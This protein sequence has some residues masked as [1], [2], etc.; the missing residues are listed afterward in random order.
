MPDRFPSPFEIQTPPGAEGWEQL[1]T[2]SSVF[3]EDRREYEEGG[4][5]F[6]DGVHWPEVL[7]PWDATFYEY[8][9]ASLSQ[10]NTR[11]YL[12]PPALGV[13]F[14]ILNGYAYL[15]PVGV[16]NPAEVEARVPHFLERA[17]FYF[18]NWDRLY[19]DWLVKIRALVKEMSEIEAEPLPEKEPIDVVTE[20]RG[21]G[22][23]LILQ[24]S[25]HKLLDLALRLWQYHFEFL[26]LGYAA[27][28]DFFGFLKQ[29]FPSIPDLAIAKMVAGVDVDLFRPDEELKKLARLAV[30]SGVDGAFDAGNPDEVRDTLRA[31]PAGQ[32]W[33]E[34]WEQA[35]EPWFNFS[36]GSGFY[37]SDR[38]WIENVDIPFGF[39]RDYIAKVKEGA[40]LARPI[41][42]L[43]AERDRIVAEYRELFSSD[44]DREAFDQKLGLARTVFPYVENHNFY[45]E[46]WSHSVLWRKMR[47]FGDVLTKAGF[48][49]EADD[50]FLLKRNEVPDALWDMYSAWAVG[51]EPRG[52]K[53][54]R[55]EIERRKGIRAALREW[56]AP[57][58]LGV[59]PEV[60]TEPFTVML[61]GITSDSVAG[62]LRASE[63]SDEGELSG[64]AA[65]P[66]VVEGPARVIF[67][68]DQ[69][70]EVEDGEI[71]VAPLTAPSWAPIFGKLLG[72]VT[73]VGGMMSH[74]AIVCREYGLPAVTGTAFGTSRIKTGQRIRLDG[75]KGTVTP[76]D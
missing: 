64:F 40:D 10:Y 17:G 31:T 53:Y 45:V 34:Q 52:G 21:T 55:P 75:N 57:P 26:N 18:Q 30:E 58:A 46:H 76:L 60:V 23:G 39:I 63:G 14:R 22:S 19:D 71:L 4:F 42:A 48:F 67:G 35:A 54:W 51:T 70:G 49:G 15:S 33:L 5:W 7:T 44:E 25:Y 37:H 3:S 8:A 66:G 27:Y 16:A 41:A 65:S 2:Y 69:I 47:A 43:H 12:I 9:L 68:A 38:I 74:A 13:D 72:T 32:A 1:Y 11:H 6:Q 28:L 56:S 29:A 20:G 24:E 59:P 36:N 73:D 62:W 61:W 50:I